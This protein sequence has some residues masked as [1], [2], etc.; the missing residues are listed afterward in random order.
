M[1]RDALD[2]PMKEKWGSDPFIRYEDKIAKL[3][4]KTFR[5]DAP[6]DLKLSGIISDG[7]KAVAI[8]NSGFYRK[9]ER[10][11]DFLIVDIG[12]DKVSLEK[13]GKRFNLEI[14]KFTKDTYKEKDKK[15][16]SP[17][18]IVPEKLQGQDGDKGKDKKN[19]KDKDKKED[20]EAKK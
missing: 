15:D 9:N 1:K 18:A 12:K 7:K 10:V 2:K 16:D 17:W 8:I 3:K 19:D 4:D 13:N 11:N 5:G 14:E 20:K 6:A